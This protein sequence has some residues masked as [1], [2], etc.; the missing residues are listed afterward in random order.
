[1]ISSPV[2]YFAGLDIW[3]KREDLYSWH[4]AQGGKA[5]ALGSILRWLAKPAGFVTCGSRFSLQALVVAQVARTSQIPSFVHCPTGKLGPELEQARDLFGAEITQHRYGYSSVLRARAIEDADRRGFLYIPSGLKHS[6]AVGGIAEEVSNTLR[7]M[8]TLPKRIVVPVG[9]GVQLA[10]ISWGRG[11]HR[12]PIVGVKVGGDPSRVLRDYSY[13]A[14]AGVEIV[15]AP[16]KY[17]IPAPAG[18]VGAI[19]GMSL[20]PY[21]EAKCVPFLRPGDL[22]WVVGCRKI[23]Q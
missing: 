2:E 15:Q 23:I 6:A 12:I 17:E 13:G 16:G 4:G 8:K 19:P 5:R 10:G 1:M 20:D 11:Q 18:L 7:F 3:V 22:F 14:G 21:Y 9:S